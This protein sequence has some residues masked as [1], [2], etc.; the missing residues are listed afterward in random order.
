MRVIRLNDGRICYLRPA[1]PKIE[2][3][4][5]L[6]LAF[7][8][9]TGQ[10]RSAVPVPA[11]W[12]TMQEADLREHVERGLRDKG[13]ITPESTAAVT[14]PATPAKRSPWWNGQRA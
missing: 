1:R 2:L 11:M 14:A 13:R 5:G 3:P 4:P 10:R 7:A 9:L 8:I 12:E 6:T